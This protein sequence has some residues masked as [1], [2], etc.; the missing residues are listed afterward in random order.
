MSTAAEAVP[1]IELP[2]RYEV[3][4]GQIL[5]IAP[6][7]A[8]ASEIANRLRDHLAAYALRTNA[9]RTRMDMAFRIPLAEDETRE[10][11]P[12]LA[13]ISFDRWPQDRPMRYRGNP[14]DVIPNLVLEV[15][16]P[17]DRAEA[18]LAK[19]DEY[20]RAGVELVWVIF[21]VLRQLYAYT[22]P[23]ASPRVFH[24]T[25]VL[26]GGNVLPGFS[27]PMAGLFPAVADEPEA[28]DDE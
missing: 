28:E 16:S 12:D 7:S 14:V 13:F 25:D 3:V 5:E 4:N 9:G 8:F 21:P 26:D 6:M 11:E 27:V 15:V 17:T 22:A 24:Q 23:D 1:E 10:R 2:D 19:A 18:V 20:R